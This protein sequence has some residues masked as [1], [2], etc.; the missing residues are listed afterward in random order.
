[1][2]SALP[3]GTFRAIPQNSYVHGASDIP[4]IGATIGECFDRTVARFP[5][6]EALGCD[7][8]V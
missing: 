1:M 4:L 5:D 2:T 6:R 8:R 3:R 7:T